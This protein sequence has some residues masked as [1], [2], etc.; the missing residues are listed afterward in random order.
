MG[1]RGPPR[2]TLHAPPSRSGAR[3][4]S[5]IVPAGEPATLPRALRQ[6]GD[7]RGHR[8][9]FTNLLMFEEVDLRAKVEEQQKKPAVTYSWKIMTNATSGNQIKKIMT[10]ATSGNQITKKIMTKR[11]PWTMGRGSVSWR[12]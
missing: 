11:H 2:Q 4:L 1:I 6:D 5:D 12:R 3:V 7:K 10:N 8:Q 9:G